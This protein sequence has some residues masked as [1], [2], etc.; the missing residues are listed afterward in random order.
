MTTTEVR[1]PGLAPRPAGTLAQ[2]CGDLASRAYARRG[3]PRSEMPIRVV[4]VDDHA[5]VRAG[6]KA[7]LRAWPDITVVAEASG[8]DEA[9]PIVKLVRPDVV[10]MDI[11]MPRGDGASTTRRLGETVPEARVLILT[12][13]PE[14]DRLAAMLSSG[15]RGYLTKDAAERELADAIR[16]VASGDIYVRPAVARQLAREDHSPARPIARSDTIEGFERL[17]ARER[18]VLALTA[19]GLNGP[20]IGRTLGITAKTVDTYK[21]RIQQKLGLAHRTEYVRFALDLHLLEPAG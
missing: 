11:D 4:L 18:T 14:H 19:K 2:M 16:V 12:M 13:F 7:L 21:Q 6:I 8:G 20:E 5:I 9:V 10:V 15:A 17:S 3:I 1:R